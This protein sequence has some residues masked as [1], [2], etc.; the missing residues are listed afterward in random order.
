M[1]RSWD[2]RYLNVSKA[3]FL[4][5]RVLSGTDVLVAILYVLYFYCSSSIYMWTVLM[6]CRDSYLYLV[7]HN[8]ISYLWA[9]RITM[10][11]WCG[12]HHS[13]SRPLSLSISMVQR[14][15]YSYSSLDGKSAKQWIFSWPKP[16]FNDFS[17]ISDNTLCLHLIKSSSWLKSAYIIDDALSA[18][19]IL[20]IGILIVLL[21]LRPTIPHALVL[22]RSGEKSKADD[23]GAFARIAMTMAMKVAVKRLFILDVDDDSCIICRCSKWR[24]R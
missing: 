7:Y 2:C 11:I 10:C 22:R 21:L 14:L 5:T 16:R 17:Y 19:D 15:C 23:D 24:Q 3:K 4:F 6:S 13:R 1:P 12:H 8:S 20:C 18:F 9:G